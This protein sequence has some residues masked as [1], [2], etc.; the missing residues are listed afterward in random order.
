M[1]KIRLTECFFRKMNFLN[2]TLI[3]L[4]VVIA[5]IAILAGMLLPALNKARRLAKDISCRNNLSTIGKAQHLYAADYDEYVVR[6]SI[7]SVYWY[8]QIQRYISP[9]F[10]NYWDGQGANGDRYARERNGKYM[11]KENV[12]NLNVRTNYGWNRYTNERPGSGTDKYGRLSQIKRPGAVVL[13]ADSESF[14]IDKA[15]DDT[16]SLGMMFCHGI[17]ANTLHP[18]GNVDG[19]SMNA[20]NLR[21]TPRFTWSDMQFYFFWTTAS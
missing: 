3:E 11:C 13:A 9:D 21:I 4:L 17:S 16:G 14:R 7:G 5:I 2:F 12:L 20:V 18:L 8:S 15:L 19:I 1:K 10:A 6:M